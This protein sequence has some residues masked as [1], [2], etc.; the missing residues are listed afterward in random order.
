[1]V[2]YDEYVETLIEILEREQY[3]DAFTLYSRKFDNLD[4]ENEY[5]ITVLNI[6]ETYSEKFKYNQ[7]LG[8]LSNCAAVFCTQNDIIYNRICRYIKELIDRPSQNDTSSS[9]Q[10]HIRTHTPSQAV[11]QNISKPRG[12][13]P[14]SRMSKR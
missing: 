7:D 2:D 5:K 9:S 1:M 6:F 3:E 8:N 13:Q 11:S 10:I 4:S 12:I 14:S